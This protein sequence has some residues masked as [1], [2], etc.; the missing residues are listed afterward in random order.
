MTTSQKLLRPARPTQSISS[1]YYLDPLCITRFQFKA[2][3]ESNSRFLPEFQIMQFS[4]ECPKSIIALV[5]LYKHSRHHLDQS[6]LC[7]LNFP[8]LEDIYKYSRMFRL[9]P[10]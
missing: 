5:L 6:E 2:A 7:H 1:T 9:I 4:V 10:R 8:A 3:C